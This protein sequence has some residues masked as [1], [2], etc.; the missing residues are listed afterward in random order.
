MRAINCPSRGYRIGNS[1]RLDLLLLALGNLG[2]GC[3][4][5]MQSLLWFTYVLGMTREM[6]GSLFTQT[7]THG[8]PAPVKSGSLA[9]EFHR[10]RD[11]VAC[12]WISWLPAHRKM[13]AFLCHWRSAWRPFHGKRVIHLLLFC[14]I[15]VVLFDYLK[16]GCAGSG[17]FVCP[18]DAVALSTILKSNFARSRLL[19]CAP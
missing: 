1:L 4:Q 2:C 11:D 9:V 18:L 16:S 13:L 12:H 10:K 8:L 3:Q 19:I 7:L 17:S 5:S 14:V 15:A 6:K